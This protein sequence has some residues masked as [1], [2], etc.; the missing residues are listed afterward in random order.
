[1][2]RAD[3]SNTLQ[4]ARF[5]FYEYRIGDFLCKMIKFFM[6]REKHLFPWTWTRKIIVPGVICIIVSLSSSSLQLIFAPSIGLWT[7][8]PSALQF[9]EPPTQSHNFLNKILFCFNQQKKFE[10][11]SYFKA[12]LQPNMYYRFVGIL[13]R[14]QLTNEHELAYMSRIWLNFRYEKSGVK[15]TVVLYSES[16]NVMS[17]LILLRQGKSLTIIS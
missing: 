16:G 12:I 15:I 2:N 5:S 1:M 3:Y 9:P 8:L 11:H 14:K 10:L 4:M 17:L 7:S 6:I 13:L